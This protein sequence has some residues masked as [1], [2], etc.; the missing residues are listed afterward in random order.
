MKTSKPS[1]KLTPLAAAMQRAIQN[2]DALSAMT[3]FSE[4]D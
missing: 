2:W 1:F 3:I 4:E